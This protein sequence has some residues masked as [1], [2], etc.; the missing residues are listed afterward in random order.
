MDIKDYTRANRAAWNASAVYHTTGAR[1]DRLVSG[2]AT[3]GF[4][5]LDETIT[6]ALVDLDVRGSS[7]VQVC[8]NNGQEILSIAG[9]G[10]RRCLG[11]DQSDEFLHTGETLA[12]IARPNLPSTT[13]VEFLCSD[14]YD[15]PASIPADFDLAVITIGVLNWMPDIQRFFEIVAGLLAPGGRLLVYET[16]PFLELF[17]PGSEDPFK[18]VY[19]YF[20]DAPSVGNE[21]IVYDD[22]APPD[23]STSYW[24]T[25]SLGDVV[26]GCV[27]AG[28]RIKELREYPHSNRETAYD[29]FERQKAQVPMC[30]TL[31]AEK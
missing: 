29:V 5:T 15:L 22:S 16:H 27:R 13:T 3:P 18:P 4:T 14:I 1:W 11:I 19:S 10:A 20:P 17:D 25:H 6:T 24:F 12:E 7:V 26:T 23:V 21:A 28:L 8:C 9:L 2:F 30:F 31:V